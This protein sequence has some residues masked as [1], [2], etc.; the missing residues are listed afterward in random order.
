MKCP[1]CES[2]MEV[3]VPSHIVTCH[4]DYGLDQVQVTQEH[5]RVSNMSSNKN[6]IIYVCTKCG[7]CL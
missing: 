2:E 1:N 5:I 7:T 6:E 4:G 3:R